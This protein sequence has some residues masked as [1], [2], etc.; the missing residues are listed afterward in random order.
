MK[1]FKL[2]VFLSYKNSIKTYFKYKL[3][4]KYNIN[5]FYIL[6]I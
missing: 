4:K 6:P 1:K 2:E 5:T 3:L